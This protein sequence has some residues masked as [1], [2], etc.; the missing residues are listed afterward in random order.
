MA[1][2][3]IFGWEVA[4]SYPLQCSFS[5][6]GCASVLLV[7]P[8]ASSSPILDWAEHPEPA[9]PEGRMLLDEVGHLEHQLERQAS[10]PLPGGRTPR[11]TVARFSPTT[12]QSRRSETWG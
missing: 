5:P 1:P 9:I 12:R 11:R 2:G 6:P 10:G 7:G 3:S 8:P 4:T